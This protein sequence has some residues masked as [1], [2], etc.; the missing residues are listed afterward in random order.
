MVLSNKEN[1]AEYPNTYPIMVESI[2]FRN[3]YFDYQKERLDF[4]RTEY[5]NYF[6]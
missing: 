6:K 2:L 3:A 1:I 5:I 4:L